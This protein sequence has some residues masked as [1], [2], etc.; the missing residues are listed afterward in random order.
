MAGFL[1]TATVD[2]VAKQEYESGCF[3]SVFLPYIK[4]FYIPTPFFART[5][6]STHAML[7]LELLSIETAIFSLQCMLK[8]ADCRE[9]LLKENL[10]DYIICMP[11]HVPPS[12]RS[13]A[14]NLV[15]TLGMYTQLQPPKLSVL[16]K[17]KIAKM[18]FGLERMVEVHSAQEIVT[19]IYGHTLSD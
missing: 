9:G 12:L 2:V 11:W 4:L 1:K 3:W 17:A 5:Q 14:D 7:Q 13:K 19:D 8:N 16:A 6:S 18:W 15:S 10:N